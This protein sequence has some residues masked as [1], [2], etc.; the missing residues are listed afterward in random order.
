MRYENLL[1]SRYIKAQKR[2]SAFTVIRIIA[3]V[4]IITMVFLLYSVFMDCLRNTEYSKAPYHLMI[5][6][7]TEEQGEALADE[8]AVRSVKLLPA[9]D[10]KVSAVI[11]FDR[12]IG[13]SFQWLSDTAAKHGFENIIPDNKY[14]WNEKLMNI[15][16]IGYDAHLYKLRIFCMFFI[17]AVFMAF[18]LRLVIDTAFEVS[19]KERERH[20][21]VLQSIGATPEQIVRIITYEG[22]K[23]C[24]IAVPL[25]LL[26]GIVLA[27]VMFNVILAAGLSELF[28]GMTNAKIYLPF[29]V[30][31]K[32]LLVAAAVGVVWVFLSAYGVGMRIIRK[33]PMEA[34]TTR[35]DEVK[36]VRKHTLSGLLFG[37]SGSIASIFPISINTVPR[38]ILSTRP[39][40]ISLV[41]SV[42]SL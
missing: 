14:A 8:E 27:Y 37:V 35:A 13:D 6:G 15:D 29:S 38:S 34:I 39:A 11:L 3:A 42:Y 1:A 41:F 9:S 21:G 2:Q 33:T 32:M 17:F 22:L 23:L 10:G 36:K 26:A 40:T 31:P 24:I 25:G 5:S 4:A 16:T 30:D 20:Y 12:D 28:H 7:L 19:S 18:A